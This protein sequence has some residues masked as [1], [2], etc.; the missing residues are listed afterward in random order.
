MLAAGRCLCDANKSLKFTADRELRRWAM[1]GSNV[2]LP[3]SAFGTFPRKRGKG[4]FEV[5][6]SGSFPR[7]RGN[8][9]RIADVCSGAA[10]R[11]SHMDVASTR[12]R[13]PEG[14]ALRG[15]V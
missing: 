6:G 12:W 7:S 10:R 9:G 3:P 15:S 2:G 14:G 13:Q 1:L 4:Y 5:S 8:I 11:A